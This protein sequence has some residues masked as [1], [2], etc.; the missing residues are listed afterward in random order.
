MQLSGDS[1]DLIDDEGDY[2]TPVGKRPLKWIDLLFW[3][4]LYI[5]KLQYFFIKLKFDII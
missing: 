2:S 1:S 3:N 5:I 4:N